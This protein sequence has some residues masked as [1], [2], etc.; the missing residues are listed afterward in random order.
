MAQPAGIIDVADAASL[1]AAIAQ[2]PP[3]SLIR[4]APGDYA[5]IRIRR[6][7]DGDPVIIE[8]PREARFILLNFTNPARGWR[9]RGVTILSGIP[10][11]PPKFASG[12]H[13]A[14]AQDIALDNVLVTGVSPG[15]DAG[16]E[17]SRGLM[18]QRASGIVIANSEI[19]HVRLIAALQDSRGLVFANNRFLDARE[20]LQVSNVQG[21]VVRGNLF[22]GWVPRFD[23]REHPDM[24]QFWTRNRPTGS[25]RV[26][27]SNNLL[28]AGEE[29]LVQ[30][31]FARAEDFEKGRLPQGFHRDWVVRNNIYFGSSKHGI[32]LSDVQG[33][34]VENNTILASPHAFVGRR[35]VSANGRS[36]S[37]WIPHILL[38]RST[39]AVVRNNLA[40]YITNTATPGPVELR[41]N[42][43]Y[44]P[45]APGDARNPGKS[46]NAPLL[47]G[48]HEPA[49]FALTRRSKARRK[50]RGADA[51]TVGPQDQAVPI[52]PLVALARALADTEDSFMKP[53]PAP[54]AAPGNDR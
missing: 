47:A 39:R 32:S 35:S 37:G 21:L 27:I 20:G 34:L 36:G 28:D 19:R 53:P 3:G 33:A 17:G 30:G 10:G 11:V 4:L 8:G 9:V 18:F 38:L 54:A 43:L 5:G 29:S 42:Q 40:P 45:M 49:D 46:F 31:I 12:V 41:N 48:T 1:T 13:F 6:R 25:A 14:R 2:A 51:S 44:R 26:E 52:E 23:L 22:R 7:I 15:P 24:I 50:G 16:D